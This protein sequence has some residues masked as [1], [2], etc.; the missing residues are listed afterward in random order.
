MPYPGRAS[1]SIHNKAACAV[2][3]PPSPPAINAVAR[4]ELLEGRRAAGVATGAM[5]SGRWGWVE[6]V[7]PLGITGVKGMA[8]IED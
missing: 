7:G 1:P 5:A 6:G 2:G 8:Q 3:V 4:R